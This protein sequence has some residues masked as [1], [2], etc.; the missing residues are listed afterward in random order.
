MLKL[1]T[2]ILFSEIPEKLADFYGKVLQTKPGWTGG[3]FVGFEAD[4]GYLVIGPHDKVHGMNTQ[5]ERMIMNFETGDVNTEF[6]RI[7][8]MG[9]KVIAEP[10]HPGE[11]KSMMLATFADPDGNYFQLASPMKQ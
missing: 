5:P 8:S 9:A 1:N 2:L 7:K 6:N 3:K 10:Y 4:G 11:D